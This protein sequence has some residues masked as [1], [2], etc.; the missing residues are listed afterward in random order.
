MRRSGAAV[1]QRRLAERNGALQ[2]AHQFRR[3]ALHPRIRHAGELVRQQLRR[4]QQVAQ[5]VVD[6]G[7]RQAEG[8]E[9]ALLMQHRHQVALHVAQFALGDADLVAALAR[10]DD[11]G[12]TLR[13]FV[14]SDQTRGQP[15]H[16]PH[17]QIMQGEIDETG[18]QARDQQ[19]DHQ[20]VAG[21]AVH[22]LAQR[23]LVDHHL[24]E[25]GAARR[26]PDHADRLVAGFQ[27]HLERIDDRRPHRHLAH[28]DVV[29]D[30]R[31][32]IGAGEQPALLPHLD[33]HRAGADAGEDLPR[34]RFRD[35]AGRGRIQHQGCGIGRRQLV[36]EPVDP[37]IGDRG[38]VDHEARDHHQRDGQQQELARQ[39]EPA[40]RTGPRQFGDWLLVGH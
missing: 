38:H 20:H 21:K 8:G 36:V 11:V 7:Y 5:V 25:L 23:R 16:R 33:G 18:G 9:P 22:R 27:H 26:R 40:R 39:A 14:E 17:E 19:R 32:Q 37:E 12:R 29:I 30:L 31:R 2:R 24:D 10:H 6:L 15:P 13:I 1:G 4:G 3:K 35:H 28:V 34:Q